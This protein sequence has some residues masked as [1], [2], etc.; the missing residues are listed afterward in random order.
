MN[1]HENGNNKKVIAIKPYN[2]KE[3]AGIYGVDPSTFKRW[4]DKFKN[5]LGEKTGRYFSIPQVKIIFLH[6]DLPSQIQTEND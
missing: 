6:L 1:T 2:T 5:E 4:L 3:L